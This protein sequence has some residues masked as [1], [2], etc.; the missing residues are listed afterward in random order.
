MCFSRLRGAL[1]WKMKATRAGPASGRA[2]G[3][4]SRGEPASQ[5]ASARGCPSRGAT[6]T[7]GAREMRN[8]PPSSLS[9]SALILPLSSTRASS[10]QALKAKGTEKHSLVSRRYCCVHHEP[11]AA[12][13]PGSGTALPGAARP[14]TSRCTSWRRLS[15]STAAAVRSA[16]SYA[17]DAASAA[18]RSSSSQPSHAA[19]TPTRHA[20]GTTTICTSTSMAGVRPP[21]GRPFPQQPGMPPAGGVPA[22][23]PQNPGLQ[24]NAA[25]MQGRL[26]PRPPGQPAGTAGV[27]SQMAGLDLQAASPAPLRLSR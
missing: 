8:H 24:P 21:A 20:H 3:R 6:L 27:E 26:S 19:S 14:T 5:P 4:P 13:S 2:N 23:G 15:T 1:S 22:A 25:A 12:A 11:A 10:G 9:L 18:R 7:L 17:A 16:T